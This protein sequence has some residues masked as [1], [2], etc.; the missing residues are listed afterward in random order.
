VYTGARASGSKLVA[1]PLNGKVFPFSLPLKNPH[2]IGDFFGEPGRTRTCNPLLNPEM[3]CSW[4]FK[5]FLASYLTV[6]G[7]VR[8][9]F[10]PKVVPAKLTHDDAAG[11]RPAE[12]FLPDRGKRLREANLTVGRNQ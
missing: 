5:H 6:L 9:G 2:F 3:L 12:I 4:L 1:R 11:N 8:Q 7:G 10:V